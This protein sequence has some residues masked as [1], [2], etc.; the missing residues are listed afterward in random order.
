M[1]NSPS[2]EA[3]RSSAIQEISRILWK[4][5]AHYDIQKR[6]PPVPILNEISPVHDAIPLI[7][8]PF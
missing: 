3:N 4:M 2:L 7:E 1:A 6:P 5:D 8:D